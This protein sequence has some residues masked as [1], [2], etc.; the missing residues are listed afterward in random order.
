MFKRI[1]IIGFIDNPLV[2]E[3]V[4]R[5]AEFFKQNQ[6]DYLVEEDTR[7]LTDLSDGEISGSR[8]E[9]GKSCDLIIVVGGDGSMLHAARDL[10]DY[11]VPLLGVN[12]G[13]LGFLTDIPPSE[14]EEQVGSVLAGEY[15]TSERFMLE[16]ELERDG[17]IVASGIALNDIVL[18]PRASIRMIELGLEIDG[19][20]VYTLRSD[21]LI[22]ATPTGSTA[23]A[24]SGGGPILHPSIN[25]INIVPINPHTLSNRPIV[26]DGESELVINIAKENRVKAQVVCDGQNHLF[27]QWGD[28]VKI[29]KKKTQIKLIHPAAHSFYETC[30]SKLRWA[31]D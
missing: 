22:V 28:K 6:I 30:R 19:K 26:V 4:N 17:E 9:M 31:Q 12:R 5:L 27:S 11:E 1:G 25:A 7:N 14:I 13:R 23:Y 18:Q 24:L 3:T 8:D 10:V 2:K 16:C 29:R 21:G 15:V 20:Y